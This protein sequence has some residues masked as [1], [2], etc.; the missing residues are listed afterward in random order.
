MWQPC[1]VFSRSTGQILRKCGCALHSAEWRGRF[2][3]E[4]TPAEA[5][6]RAA[7]GSKEAEV[8]RRTGS[9]EEGNWVWLSSQQQNLRT[10][11]YQSPQQFSRVPR[12]VGE[13]CRIQG[14]SETTK[15]NHLLPAL[16]S[17]F[18]DCVRPSQSM[19]GNTAGLFL[20]DGSDPEGWQK[21]TSNLWGFV[22]KCTLIGWVG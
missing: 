22:E 19:M 7:F 5:E 14:G 12:V 3:Q 2:L 13:F 16:T 11:C 8:G 20:K 4:A 1:S 17:R 10:D 6:V 15:T 21:T 9:N 18:V